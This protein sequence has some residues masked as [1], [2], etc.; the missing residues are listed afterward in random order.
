MK[1]SPTLQRQPTNRWPRSALRL[2]WAFGVILGLFAVAAANSFFAVANIVHSGAEV[3]S[4]Q[5]AAQTAHEVAALMREQYIHQAHTLLD[6]N[7]SHLAHYDIVARTAVSRA[8]ELLRAPLNDEER[9]LAT[10]VLQRIQSSNT[11]FRSKIV[12]SMARMEP[13]AA[14][15]LSR[16]LEVITTQVVDSV[17][18]LNSMIEVQSQAVKDRALLL[19]TRSRWVILCCFGLALLLAAVLA[20][21]HVRH[22]AKRLNTLRR[23]VFALAQGDLSVRIGSKEDDEFGE[24]ARHFDDMAGALQV[25]QTQLLRAKTLA[26]L[27]EMAAA[28]AHEINNPLSVILGYTKIMQR[29]PGADNS[30]DL[31]I[32]EGEVRQCQAIVQDLLDLARP[33]RLDLTAVDVASLIRDVV[34]R[35]REAG[36]LTSIRVEETVPHHA[37]DV[38]G[39]EQRLRQVLVNIITNAVQAMP[40]GGTISITVEGQ[41]GSIR[42]R[43]SDTGLGIT[44]NDVPHVVDPFF[45]TKANGTGLG[46]TICQSIME[47]HN[48]TL[49][50]NTVP[51]RGTTVSLVFR[52]L[53]GA[54]SAAPRITK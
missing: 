28:V 4:L 27:G 34:T 54:L 49:S 6:W 22:V 9:L 1:T 39:D 51:G 31:E 21:S 50:I 29:T 23:G 37:A 25:Q 45:S 17:A 15:T 47:A 41:Q 46:L 52:N 40:K 38:V 33:V 48:G 30:G 13:S 2:L 11:I 12:P 8:N 16:E 10:A 18:T 3:A 43:I 24:L 14:S 19:Q 26:S 44:P 36:L 53:P 5:T 32:I 7:T 42:I 20:V 35:Q